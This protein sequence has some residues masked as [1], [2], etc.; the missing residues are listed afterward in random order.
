[1]GCGRHP[2]VL[3]AQAPAGQHVVRQLALV[4][5]IMISFREIQARQLGVG[6]SR[7]YVDGLQAPNSVQVK[8]VIFAACSG[9]AE[10]HVSCAGP[11]SNFP[12]DTTIYGDTICKKENRFTIRRKLMLDMSI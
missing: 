11:M 5:K 9:G 4:I 8:P 2:N 7:G 12:C 6:A 3:Q 1:M 10:E